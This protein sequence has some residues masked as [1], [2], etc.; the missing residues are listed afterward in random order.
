MTRRKAPSIAVTPPKAVFSAAQ[1]VGQGREIPSCHRKP[2]FKDY[3]DVIVAL[4]CLA[5]MAGTICFAELD[6]NYMNAMRITAA[7]RRALHM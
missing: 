3:A 6:S 7:I 2:S 1:T 4:V 5:V